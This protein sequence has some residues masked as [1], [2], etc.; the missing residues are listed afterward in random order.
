[1]GDGDE[2]IYDLYSGT[3]TIAQILAGSD[4][5][6]NDDE[7]EGSY[8]GKDLTDE[9]RQHKRKV[10]GVE[11]VEE[12]V[13]AA[14]VNAKEN[15]L[16]NCTF[17]AGDVLKVLDDLTEP[18]QLIVLDPPRDGIHPKALPKILSYRAKHLLYVACKPTIL[19]RDLGPIFEAGYRIRRIICVDQFPWTGGVEVICLLDRV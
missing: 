8:K 4:Y 13:E 7:K 3:G 10:I 14:R 1:M 15:G 2:T 17:I 5:F 9:N 6:G 11:I 16:D 19:E 12:A 18:P